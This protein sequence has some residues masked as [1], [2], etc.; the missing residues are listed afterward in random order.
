[1]SVTS[2]KIVNQSP[3]SGRKTFTASCDGFALSS[4]QFGI[5]SKLR[6]KPL[7]KLGTAADPFRFMDAHCWDFTKQSSFFQ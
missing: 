2:K 1:M 7:P 6:I 4:Q 5:E 3:E